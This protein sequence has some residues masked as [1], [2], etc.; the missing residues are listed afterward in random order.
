MP[1]CVE[2]CYLLDVELRGVETYA[3]DAAVSK[4]VS[5]GC[6]SGVT[7]AT[8]CCIELRHVVK[9]IYVCNLHVR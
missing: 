1:P 5:E 9:F 3:P 8:Q 7:Q 6:P 2:A 4:D